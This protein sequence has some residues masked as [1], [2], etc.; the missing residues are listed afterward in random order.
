MAD[1]VVIER[2]APADSERARA[3]RLRA[4]RGAPDAFWTT[5]AEEE[6]RPP[7]LWRE[8]LAAADAATFVAHR[9]GVDVG[10]IVG[11]PHHGH[12]GD[13]GLFSMWVAPE[14]RGKGVAAALID[15]V[16]AWAR[17]QGYRNLHLAVAD[18]NE[19]AA[20]LYERMGFS[21]TGGGGSFPPPREHITEH[22]RVLDLTS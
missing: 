10:L 2:L 14:A 15:A 16:V 5:L 13:A 11:A 22:E 19:A 4:L 7:E 21:A 9:G 20:R 1:D 18:A 6:Q 12:E 8:R 3:I 17:E